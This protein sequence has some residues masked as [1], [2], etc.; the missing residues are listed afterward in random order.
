MTI[1]SDACSSPSR[2]FY[3]LLKVR[4]IA[5]LQDSLCRSHSPSDFTL[6]N[7]RRDRERERKI[8][9]FCLF[10][11]D[12]ERESERGAAR[13]IP[14]VIFLSI[15]S[16]VMASTQPGAWNREEGKT[17]DCLLL[18]HVSPLCTLSRGIF[19]AQSASIALLS[20]ETFTKT[21]LFD[22]WQ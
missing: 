10:S 18:A 7:L 9:F 14:S 3:E 21:F 12:S 4:P 20:R 1:L 16:T 5:L 19:R 15:H 13:D 8:W 6:H 2:Q 22:N 17:S 11:A